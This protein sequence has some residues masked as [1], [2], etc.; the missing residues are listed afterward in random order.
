MKKLILILTIFTLTCITL[1]SKT[2]YISHKD[3]VPFMVQHNTGAY[4]KDNCG[5]ASLKMA[6][7][8]MDV[9]AGTIQ[10]LRNEIKPYPN[11]IYTDELEEYLD[12][13]EVEYDII[14]IDNKETIIEYLNDGI[15]LMC[16]DMSKI[17]TQYNGVTGHF[18]IV[19]GYYI[20]S[21]GEW[22]EVYDPMLYKTQCYKLEEV[23]TSAKSWW[24][25]SFYF[26]QQKSPQ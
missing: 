9:K 25:Y 21:K 8:F 7:E 17:T 6:L 22:L 20:D 5:I 4:S 11:W 26:T 15:L 24:E 12:K 3:E 13:R 16:L 1:L 2:T 23:Y 10:Q 18:I 14:S 19:V